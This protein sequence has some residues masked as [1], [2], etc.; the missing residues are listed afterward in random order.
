[1]P[2]KECCIFQQQA[3]FIGFDLTSCWV[4]VCMSKCESCAQVKCERIGYVMYLRTVK[5]SKHESDETTA[6]ICD[7]EG[8]KQMEN[9]RDDETTTVNQSKGH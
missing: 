2:Q 9:T 3:D 8:L 5:G 7:S 6:R 4:R 1:M